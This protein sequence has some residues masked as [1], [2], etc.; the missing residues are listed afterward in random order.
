MGLGAIDKC[1]M[2]GWHFE[3]DKSNSQEETRKH[4]SGGELR[5]LRV[6]MNEKL[7]KKGVP[8]STTIIVAKV[9]ALAGTGKRRGGEGGGKSHEVSIQ[10]SESGTHLRGSGY[11][12]ISGGHKRL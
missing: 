3:K 7:R 5:N 12:R 8:R 9:A 6:E 4:T 11:K 10:R 1:H 2:G